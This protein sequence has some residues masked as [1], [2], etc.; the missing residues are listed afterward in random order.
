MSCEFSREVHA[1]H[2]G[3][4]TGQR[5]A[6]VGEHLKACAACQQELREL[7]GLSVMLGGVKRPAMAGEVRLRLHKSIERMGERSV[8]RIAEA[9]SAAAAIILAIGLAAL[10]SGRPALPGSD[11]QQVSVLDSVVLPEETIPAATEPV[12]VTSPDPLDWIER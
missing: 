12:Q 11:S 5:M 10:M 7:E 3:E 8:L 1:W 6:A 9:L 4:L 2:D